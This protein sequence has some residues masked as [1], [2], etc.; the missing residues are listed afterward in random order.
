[1]YRIE[2]LPLLTGLPPTLH[3]Y[4][5]RPRLGAVDADR[6]LIVRHISNYRDFRKSGWLFQHHDAMVPFDVSHK[7]LPEDGVTVKEQTLVTFGTS[8]Q[9]AAATRIF[10]YS[11]SDAEQERDWATLAAEGVLVSAAYSLR[12]RRVKPR[13]RILALDRTWTIEDFGYNKEDFR[14]V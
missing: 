14:D 1:M 8:D 7:N 2:P 6:G 13:V 4:I 12:H 10:R 5:Q 11:F 3:P 9:V